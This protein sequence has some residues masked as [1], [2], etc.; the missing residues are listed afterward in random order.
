MP[1]ASGFVVACLLFLLP[2]SVGAQPL[3]I[4]SPT[5]GQRLASGPDYATEVLGDP[6]DMDNRED[7]SLLEPGDNSGFSTLGL[8][9]MGQLVGTLSFN[10][11]GVTFL[12]RGV[13]GAVNPGRSGRRFPIDPHA[14]SKLAFKLTSTIDDEETQAYWHHYPH[15]HPTGWD[16][17]GV[18]IVPG[19]TVVGSK[20]FVVDLAQLNDGIPGEE[21]T[22]AP[23]VGLRIDPNSSAASIGHQMSFDWVRLVPGDS[24]PTSPFHTVQWSGPAG[25]Y[26][27]AVTELG[28]PSPATLQIASGVPGPSYAWRYGLLPP[29]RY[30]LTITR[31][32]TGASAS[33]DFEINAPPLLHVVDPDE[34]GGEDFAT[35]VLGNPWDMSDPADVVELNAVASHDF[36]GG[37]L[38]GTSPAGA[39]G[40]DSALLL[41]RNHLEASP[42]IDPA[43]YHRLTYRMT[44]DGVLDAGPGGSVA[45]VFWGSTA[46]RQDLL[47]GTEDLLVWTGPNTYTVDL[48]TLE[49]GI[50]VG[51]EPPPP[52]WNWPGERWT[53]SRKRYFRLDPHE[54]TAGRSFHI[55][56]VRLAADD[57]AGADGIFTIR[58]TWSDPDAGDAPRVRLY[59]DGDLDAGNGHTFLADVPAAAGEYAWDTSTL[60]P[61]LYHVYAEVSDG[62]NAT[63]RYSTGPVNTGPVASTGEDCGDCI[64]NDGNGRTDYEDAACCPD[65]VPLKLMRGRFVGTAQGGMARGRLFLR[66]G[67]DAPGFAGVDLARD[68]VGVQFRN[69]YGELLCG[70]VAAS[71][72]KASGRQRFRFRDRSRALLPGIDS[73]TFRLKRGDGAAELKLSS[74]RIDL[75]PYGGTLEVAVRAGHRCAQGAARLR[76]RGRHNL[77]LP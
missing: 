26:T 1:I 75:R 4:T 31:D 51:I 5:P 34:A 2:A 73:A 60:P 29:G 23:V 44:L 22:V 20:V 62:R 77:S 50:D 28:A 42:L 19:M 55:D 53:D 18:R 3:S 56:D 64:D 71:R 59:A 38:H 17:Y 33:V 68:D 54:G 63:A 67:V 9:G 48:S 76:V 70:R 37:Q 25:T 49:L 45:R 61:G 32:S 12:Y 21:W 13:S 46:N 65:A 11:A 30:R 47:S 69:V 52:Q 16:R 27:L 6:W 10:D 35:T 74:Q 40:G 43:V 36:S 41:F 58:W 24:T 57:R 7:Y 8:N 14:F 72:W 15:G 39:A 66:A